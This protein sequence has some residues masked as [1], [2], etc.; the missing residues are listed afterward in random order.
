MT[1]INET[2]HYRTH[3]IWVKPGHHLYDYFKQSCE[4]AKNLH[5]ATNFVIRQ[6]FTALTSVEEP[7]LLQK[8]VLDALHAFID[9]M[10]EVQLL[11]YQKRQDRERAKPVETRKEVKA[12]VFTLPTKEK[13]MINY[14]FLDAFFKATAQSNYRALPTQS[15]Q[16]IMKNAFASWK[17]FFDS[18]KA[19]KQKKSAFT[20]KPKMPGYCRSKQKEVTFSNQDCVIK[21]KKYLKFPL[22]KHRLSIGKLG[23]SRDTLMQ[24]RV[25]P[26]YQ[27]YVVELV[28]TSEPDQE[29]KA[30]SQV[31]G[32]DLGLNNLATMV[33]N[34]GQAPL[35]VKGK[36]VKAINQ[37]YNKKK[38]H[39]M[40][41]L[42]QGK[43]ANEG[44][45]SS[46]RL[47]RLHRKRALKI[48]DFFHKASHHIVQIAKKHHIGTIVI[49]QNTQ[50]KHEIQIGKK[51]NQAFVHIP[52]AS[53]IHMVTYKAKRAGILVVV[54]EES[55]TS[56]SSFLD[57]DD[58]PTYGEEVEK[59]TFSGKRISRGMYRSASGKMI[60]A[61][62]N[63]AYN[64]LR[65]E[66]PNAFA[67][68]IEGLDNLSVV[69]VST[70]QVIS[71]R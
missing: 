25:I 7:K 47:D 34:T 26:S 51:N 40:S 8:E 37:Y 54:R 12:H 44:N 45:Y 23:K 9:P 68:G 56:T 59:V 52:H 19:Y 58:I 70:P 39:L 2:S 11:A 71:I 49:G 27:Q 1:L 63:G 10:N 38:S 48:K 62:V 21:E 57:G 33:T 61:D 69:A 55:Y 14:S 32:I 24:V 66:V 53:L 13:P 31:M 16:Q 5:N 36:A 28:F 65:K 6:T 4:Q 15:S 35:L 67:D 17:G 64:I 22:T 20:G 30:S 41:I 50:W 60:N 43:A 18:L 3:Q 29:V 42:R 46:K